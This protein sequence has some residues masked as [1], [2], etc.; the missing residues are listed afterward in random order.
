M[1]EIIEKF[2]EMPEKQKGIVRVIKHRYFK[3]KTFKKRQ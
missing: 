3:A 2:D 1:A